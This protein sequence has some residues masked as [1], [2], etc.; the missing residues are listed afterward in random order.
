MSVETSA[1]SLLVKVVSNQTHAAT[2][3]EETV[4]DT[5]LHVVLRL[6]SGESTAVAHE[7][8]EAHSNAT[9]DVENEV[10]LLGSCDSLNSNGIIQQLSAGEVFLHVVLDQLNTKIRVVAGLDTV[11]DSGN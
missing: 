1:Q 3:N 6:L 8:H 5:H 10:V 4:E 7:I 2:Q 9:V 11:T